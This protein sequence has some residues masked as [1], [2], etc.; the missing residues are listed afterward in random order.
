MQFAFP[1]FLIAL[2]SILIPLIIHLFYFQRYRTEYFSNVRFL[3]EL[4]EEKQT[5]SRL[6]NILVLLA[7]I[8]FLVFLVL[9]FAQPFLQDRE[10]TEN[11][12]PDFVSLFIDN[13]YSMEGLSRETPVFQVAVNRAK[14]IIRSYP[15]ETSFQILTNLLNPAAS[16]VVDRDMAIGLVDEIE[17]SSEKTNLN[18]IYDFVLKTAD[19]QG[20]RAHAF[21]LSDF[22]QNSLQDPIIVDSALTV[23]PVP[24]QPLEI[25]NI[26]IDSCWFE[27]PV[28][29]AN[30]ENQ[31]YI[32][33]T[34]YGS[35][36]SE[37]RIVWRENEE[38]KPV[39]S[40]MIDPGQSIIDTIGI[41]LS[42]EESR[43]LTLEVTDHPITFDN[44]YYLQLNAK[45]KLKI[46]IIDNGNQNRY[47]RSA[48]EQQPMVEKQFVSTDRV[49]YSEFD[50]Q[51]LIILDDLT[52]I[53]SGLAS[54][55]SRYV[56]Q[57]G[58]LLIF[59]GSGITSGSINDF[60]RNTGHVTL[61]AWMQVNQEALGLN[62]EDFVF[63]DVFEKKQ[64]GIV[65]P[66]VNGYYTLASG[67]QTPSTYLIRLRNGDPLINK[68][69]TGN[70]LLYL[71]TAPLDSRWN[72]LGNHAD[73]FIPML[74]RMALSRSKTNQLAYFIGEDQ[75][76]QISTDRQ[77]QAET[78]QVKNGDQQFIPSFRQSGDVVE[79]FLHDQIT[80]A[81]F[82]TV[83]EGNEKL[84]DFAM[85]YSREESDVNLWTQEQLREKIT[86]H[87]VFMNNEQMAS[88][89]KFIQEFD[90]G[91]V[92]WKYCLIFALVFLIL[93]SLLLRFFKN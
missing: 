3:K 93:E 35:S 37:S 49:I 6:R 9:A 83:M 53:N 13:S 15:E 47:L 66:S 81:G 10:G 31:M 7:R 40:V 91:R 61:G 52:E 89:G 36:P 17:L 55:L 21:W 8:F 85:N 42:G 41:Q 60:L 64:T 11:D 75:T 2:A 58:N 33:L 63:S 1:L 76:I 80:Q 29:E 14:E 46:L 74:Y 27:S 87:T 12:T 5:R 88:L 26:S 48:F 92:F 90:R 82:Y 72:T 69:F 4:V 30:Q 45:R 18:Q 39:S 54:N 70:G 79:I 65:L 51:D 20:S 57:G 16:R 19:R 84:A 59:P 62:F 38:V 77:L 32:K 22:Q 67:S 24:L 86:G 28:P 68:I 78:I 25:R 43:A 71:S 23:F 34:N 73:I 56:E 50:Q 44:R